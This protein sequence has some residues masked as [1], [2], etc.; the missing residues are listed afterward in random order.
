MDRIAA[1]IGTGTPDKPVL[2]PEIPTHDCG[3]L[4][5]AIYAILEYRPGPQPLERLFCSLRFFMS[6]QGRDLNNEAPG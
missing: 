4:E 1:Q 3:S 5:K 6:C 2:S